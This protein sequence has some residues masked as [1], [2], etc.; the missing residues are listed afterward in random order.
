MEK[1]KQITTG[2]LT[3]DNNIIF[4]RSSLLQISS[5]ASIDVE[6]KP[7]KEAK[8]FSYIIL[9]IGVLLSCLALNW[10]SDGMLTFGIAL[11]VAAIGYF[12]CIA[13]ENEYHGERYLRI[14]LNSGYVYSIYCEDLSFLGEVTKILRN[15]MNDHLGGQ[16]IKIDFDHC[17][18]KDSNIN[19]RNVAGEDYS[20]NF[21]GTNTF[22]GNVFAEGDN[23][24]GVTITDSFNSEVSGIQGK[25]LQEILNSIMGNLS[26]LNEKD[27]QKVTE[28]VDDVAEAFSGQEVD[29]EKLRKCKRIITRLTTV[30]KGVPAL[31]EN[32]QKLGDFIMPYINGR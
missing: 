14:Y 22:Q 23:Y 19:P 25:E 13:I 31:A 28:T 8:P 11:I 10:D 26:G 32:L 30:A 9:V 24:G 7:K 4:S 5:I 12:I 29:S 15:C 27:R 6:P 16:H 18:I 20:M 17:V 1:Q 2:S 3:I 21:S